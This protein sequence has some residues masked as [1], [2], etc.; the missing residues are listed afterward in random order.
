MKKA[1]VTWQ[2][3]NLADSLSASLFCLQNIQIVIW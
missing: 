2:I 3:F 1:W